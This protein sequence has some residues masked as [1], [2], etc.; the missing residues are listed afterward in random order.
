MFPCRSRLR[1]GKTELCCDEGP[2]LEEQPPMD[3]GRQTK[4]AS[5]LLG[6]HLS[7]EGMGQRPDPKG[8]HN[9]FC[10]RYNWQCTNQLVDTFKILNFNP[11]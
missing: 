11:P 7:L 5:P 9:S 10:M 4:L 8:P 3:E 2:G 1:G 6:N